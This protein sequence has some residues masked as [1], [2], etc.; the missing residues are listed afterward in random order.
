MIAN[1]SVA[2]RHTTKLVAH[3][4]TLHIPVILLA[5]ACMVAPQFAHAAPITFAAGD[6]DN[7]QNQVNAG[8]TPVNNQTTGKFR[9]IFWWGSATGVGDNDYI[10]S[11][12]NLISNG[13]S[14]A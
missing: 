1:Q 13:G 14:P 7:T 8:P 11:G 4:P 3:H 12:K 10:N 9:D 2:R 5:I 6:Y